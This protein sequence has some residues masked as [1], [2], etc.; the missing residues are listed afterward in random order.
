MPSSSA[1]WILRAY[2][3]VSTAV[4]GPHDAGVV[5]SFGRMWD[6]ERVCLSLRAFSLP[7]PRLHTPENQRSR[8]R[9]QH[10]WNDQNRVHQLAPAGDIWSITDARGGAFVP[11]GAP[12][13]YQRR[14]IRRHTGR[15]EAAEK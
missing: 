10:A 8:S 7:P 13:L 9:S 14:Q 1:Q 11:A 5:V 3:S 6:K 4:R 12:H 15:L 2:R